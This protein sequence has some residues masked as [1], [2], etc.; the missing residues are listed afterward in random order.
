MQ[1]YN[2]RMWSF[3]SANQQRKRW[4]VQREERRICFGVP[5]YVDEW[6]DYM[7]FETKEEADKEIMRLQSF[8]DPLSRTRY[9][10]VDR[11]NERWEVRL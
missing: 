6:T 9:Q 3:D 2:T 8:I 7:S 5:G 1:E 10:I 11:A 4:I